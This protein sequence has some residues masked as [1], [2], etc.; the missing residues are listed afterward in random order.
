MPIMKHLSD[1]AI[2]AMHVCAL[3]FDG[4]KYE[5]E[6]KEE[7]DGSTYGR[8]CTLC[9]PV[10]D[11]MLLSENEIVNFAAF[12][13]LQRHFHWTEHD[14]RENSRDHLVFGLLFLHLYRKEVPENYRGG[15]FWLKWRNEY[16]SESERF[17]GMIR[18]AFI[19]AVMPEGA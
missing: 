11:N 18:M 13:L 14:P 10:L 5:E 17:A 2:E 7:S 4:G 8:T 16:E 6:C 9:R 1:R 12:F 3:R 15:H 19:R